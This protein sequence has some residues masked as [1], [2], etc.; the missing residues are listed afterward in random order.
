VNGAHLIPK[1]AVTVQSLGN[2]RS[3]AG[4]LTVAPDKYVRF[5]AQVPTDGV[6]LIFS[7]IGATI[8]FTAIPAALACI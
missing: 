6:D 5:Q 3:V 8:A 1:Y 7:D 2:N 4:H